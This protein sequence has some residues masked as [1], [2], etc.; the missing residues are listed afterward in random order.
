MKTMP[1]IVWLDLDTEFGDDG[2]VRAI[3]NTP[4][5]P[6]TRALLSSV[7]AVDRTVD[8]LYSIPGHPPPLWDLPPGCRF[9]ARCRWTEPRCLDSYP[10]MLPGRRAGQETHAASCWKLEDSGWD[11]TEC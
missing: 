8:R 6:Y 9:A 11:N 7:P 1:W 2:S 4:A 5:H 10:P 3:F